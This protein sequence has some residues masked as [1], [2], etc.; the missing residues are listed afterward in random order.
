MK[1]IK[2][3]DSFLKS[4][5]YDSDSNILELEF[6]DGEIRHYFGVSNLAYN[7]LVAS[8]FPSTYFYDN[9]AFTHPFEIMQYAYTNLK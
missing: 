5:E 7:G 2:V 9:I 4:I 3:K 6:N 1:K 8:E